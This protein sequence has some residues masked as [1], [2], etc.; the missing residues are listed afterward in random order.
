MQIP[1]TQAGHAQPV[2]KG[3]ELEGNGESYVSPRLRDDLNESRSVRA[4]W[5]SCRETS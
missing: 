4:V 1:T 2:Q 3:R 5:L